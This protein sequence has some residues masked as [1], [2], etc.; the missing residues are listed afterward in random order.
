MKILAM[1]FT[2]L[3]CEMEIFS[4][5]FPSRTRCQ[6]K[7]ETIALVHIDERSSSMLGV[8]QVTVQ[9]TRKNSDTIYNY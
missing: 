8:V 6:L 9:C 5:N 3:P 2:R 4:K 7:L 1:M